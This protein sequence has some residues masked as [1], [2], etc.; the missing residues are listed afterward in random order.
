MET[1]HINYLIKDSEIV[2]EGLLNSKGL[3]KTLKEFTF[4]DTGI[5][6]HPEIMD[7]VLFSFT[8]SCESLKDMYFD[9][10][11][12]LEEYKQAK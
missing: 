9:V 3:Q 10:D 11:M 6:N 2:V 8:E 5:E 12:S 7:K 1:L 4:E